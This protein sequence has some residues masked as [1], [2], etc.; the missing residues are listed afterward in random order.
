MVGSGGVGL[1]E[2]G[3]GSP[4]DWQDVEGAVGSETDKYN[5]IRKESQIQCLA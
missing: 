1:R 2:F 3:W 4:F 5:T